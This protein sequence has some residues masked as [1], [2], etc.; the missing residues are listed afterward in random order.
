MILDIESTISNKGNPFDRRNKLVVTGILD[1]D[2]TI[3]YNDS[4]VQEIQ[5]KLD[6]DRF[7]VAFNAKFDLHWLRRVGYDISNLTVWDCQ[8]AHFLL[9]NQTTPFPSLNDVAAFYGL[10]QK[11]DKI[12]LDYWDKGI[13]TDQIP[14]PELTSYLKQDLL[15]TQQVYEKQ[16]EQFRNDGRFPLF[17]LQ[18]ADLLVLE[19]MEWNGIIFNT[20]EALKKAG[21]IKLELDEIY[22][23]L[24][25]YAG[26][27]PFNPSSN[28][29][30][31]ALIYGGTITECIRIPVGVYKSG[32]RQGEVRYKKVEKIYTLPR[33]VEPLEGTQREKE[34]YWLVNDT[35]LRSL[36]LDKTAKKVVKLLTQYSEKEKLKGTYLE[37]YAKLIEKMDWEP[38]TLHPT[39]NQCVAITGRTSSS[40]PNGQN[41]DP[42]T[43]LFMETRYSE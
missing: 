38:G 28:D 4:S 42:I 11:E 21:E 6:N 43:K 15:L 1:K 31:S 22:N 39:I 13:D 41:A 3:C 16:R 9:N 8:L 27:V 7:L 5:T 36:K 12:K 19:E 17:K 34:G 32:D 14:R 25:G 10:G 26:G 37:G 40:K 30:I 18:S 20:E 33:L 2:Y 29:H 35:V 23:N 24:L